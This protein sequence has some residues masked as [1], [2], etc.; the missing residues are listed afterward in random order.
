MRGRTWMVDAGHGQNTPSSRRDPLV[1]DSGIIGACRRQR[2]AAVPRNTS[3]RSDGKPCAHPRRVGELRD[4]FQVGAY[5]GGG[6]DRSLAQQNAPLQVG[7]RPFFLRPLREGRT[8]SAHCCG[9]RQEEIGHDQKVERSR[10]VSLRGPRAEPRPPCLTRTPAALG[11]LLP[12]PARPAFRRPSDPAEAGPVPGRP[13]WRRCTPVFG[14]IEA[15]GTPAVGPPSGRAHG[16]PDRF[17]VRSDSRSR[18]AAFRPCP[19]PA[20]G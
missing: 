17:P 6:V 15:S 19:A 4:H 7:H 8:T 5:T 14:I 3:G 10:A 1:G 9:L 2:L 11:R 12:R 16:L 20:P 18:T 13:R